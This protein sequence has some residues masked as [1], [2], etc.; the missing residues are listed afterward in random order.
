MMSFSKDYV[1]DSNDFDVI[2]MQE[3]V[4]IKDKQKELD[5]ARE[6]ES[7]QLQEKE[8]MHL[9]YAA[10]EQKY[11]FLLENEARIQEEIQ[12]FNEELEQLDINKGDASEE[13]KNKEA[14]IKDIQDTIENSKEL[15]DEIGQEGIENIE[16]YISIAKKIGL[17]MKEESGK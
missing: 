1:Y 10:S 6:E 12:K 4:W 16:R 11:Q 15:F 17:K 9:A 5:E 3:A 13:I 8:N 14:Q 2:C 7:K